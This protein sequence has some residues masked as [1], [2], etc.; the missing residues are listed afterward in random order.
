MIEPKWLD[1]LID[2]TMAAGG[3]AIAIAQAIATAP[4]F[5]TAIEAGLKTTIKPGVIGPNPS[6]IVAI[7]IK[8]SLTR[9]A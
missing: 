4:Q 7:A 3:D 2:V 5:L 8:D 9:E 6:Q 1:K